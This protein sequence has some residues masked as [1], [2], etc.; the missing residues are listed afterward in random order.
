MTVKRVMD[1]APEESW[2]VERKT[3]TLWV[4]H[5]PLKFASRVFD[6]KDWSDLEEE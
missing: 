6:W 5:P 2:S 3:R 4:G 1:G